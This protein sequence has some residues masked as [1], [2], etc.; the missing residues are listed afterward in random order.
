MLKLLVILFVMKLYDRVN[1][2][3][4]HLFHRSISGAAE[5]LLQVPDFLI[6]SKLVILDKPLIS[7]IAKTDFS[8]GLIKKIW[9][10][11]INRLR[12]SV[13]FLIGIKSMQGWTAT[14][15][16]G[17]TNKRKE[18]D[19]NLIGKLF[20]KDKRCLLTLDFKPFRS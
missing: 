13:F 9:F 18:K 11:F 4:E 7:W 15:R 17:V 10:E 3:S 8:I 1:I 20:R 12:I 19:K 2:F 16:H 5:L 6:S 14:T